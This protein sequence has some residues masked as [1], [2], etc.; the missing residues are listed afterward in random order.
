MAM[1]KLLMALKEDP[2]L[3]E[4]WQGEFDKVLADYGIDETTRAAWHDRDLDRLGQIVLAEL[5]EVLGALGHVK[6]TAN[7][8]PG[9]SEGD[10]H[11]RSL[12]CK[13][14]EAGKPNELAVDLYL[15]NVQSSNPYKH[16]RVDY[17]LTDLAT[18]ALVV[19]PAAVPSIDVRP[20]TGK[21]N[22]ATL[23]FVCTAPAGSYTVKLT[24]KAPG[25]SD[26]NVSVTCTDPYVVT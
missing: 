16:K 8:W 24:I 25:E 4:A 6:L 22:A 23:T 11:Y 1:M 14:G 5:H 10:A 9:P 13:P 12:N 2:A 19:G 17:T 3:L 18:G 15:T 20:K 26:N 21:A 7:T